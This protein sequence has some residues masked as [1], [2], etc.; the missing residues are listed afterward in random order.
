MRKA[1][2]KNVKARS[3]DYHNM[4]MALKDSADTTKALY[5]PKDENLLPKP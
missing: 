5:H 2:T 3:V 1:R 4:T